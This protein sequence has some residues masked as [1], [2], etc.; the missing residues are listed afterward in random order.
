MTL[1]LRPVVIVVVA[2]SLLSLA[3]RAAQVQ[4]LPVPQLPTEPSVG[5]LSGAD[6]GFRMERMERGRAVGRLV[7]R[8]DGKWVDAQFAT[9]VV[10][11][12]DR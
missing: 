11:L 8:V 2:V 3:A 5:V 7:V 10:R 6:I 4:P 1:R 9:G 12:G